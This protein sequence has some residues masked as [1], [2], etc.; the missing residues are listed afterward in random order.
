MSKGS[1][2]LNK[3]HKFI[4]QKYLMKEKENPE[5]N[6]EFCENYYKPLMEVN[7]ELAFR[8]KVLELI[9]KQPLETSRCI[10]YLNINKD[11]PK[12]LDYDHYIMTIKDTVSEEVFKILK[13]E[14]VGDE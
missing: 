13:Y 3:I 6:E 8:D 2:N 5:Y 9:K 10:H 7:T 12:M 14:V 11:C 4:N 1:D